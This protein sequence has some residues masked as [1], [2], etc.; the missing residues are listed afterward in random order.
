M[1]SLFRYPGGK[2]KLLP[3]IMPFIENSLKDKIGFCDA[4]VGGGSV[5]LEVAEKYPNIPLYAN[6]K[7]S[8]VFSFWK[9][10]ASND[11]SDLDEL[12][13]LIQ[14]KPTIDLFYELRET[15]AN[16]IAEFAYRAVFFN[17]TSFSG[18]MRRGASPIG[19]K[20]QKSKYTVD[21]RY[22][23]KKLISKIDEIHKLLANRTVVSNEDINEYNVLDKKNI[24]VYLDPPYFKKGKMLYQEYMKDKEHLDLSNWLKTKNNWI[25][26]YDN[27]EEIREL[28]N[29]ANIQLIDASY[30]I[31]GSKT[32]WNKTKEVLILPN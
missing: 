12:K 29:W 25:L 14:L 8:F 23:A 15:E 30:C 13:N 3:Q 4:F 22:N 26:S 28:Y 21:C 5:L 27:C 9:L 17:R 24:S 7:D 10:V 16:S 18:D 2:N 31:K 20:N 6:D 1:K 32:N 11:W 19:G